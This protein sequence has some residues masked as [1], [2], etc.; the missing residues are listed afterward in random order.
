MNNITYIFIL[1]ISYLLLGCESE[2]LTEKK[3]LRVNFLSYTKIYSDKKQDTIEGIKICFLNNSDSSIYLPTGKDSIYFFYNTN[4]YI[5]CNTDIGHGVIATNHDINWIELKP[6]KIIHL[7]YA[8]YLEVIK[9]F[10]V[11]TISSHY[12]NSRKKRIPFK[13]SCYLK[14]DSKLET[15]EFSDTFC[16][17]LRENNF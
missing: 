12:K 3:S 7:L 17:E 2:Q 1:L 4:S 6:N 16:R 10:N 11:V 14:R 9:D 15:I 5:N 13:I 8:T